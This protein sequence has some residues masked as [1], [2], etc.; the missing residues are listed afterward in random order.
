MSDSSEVD[1]FILAAV[2]EE[3]G[4]KIKKKKRMSTHCIFLSGC[5]EGEFHILTQR[6]REDP[7]K[8]KQYFRT[9]TEKLDELLNS[10]YIRP[11]TEGR[12]TYFESS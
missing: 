9:S 7:V 3:I 6:L 4:K 8:H 11:E 2:C 5:N 1:V 12:N 10:S